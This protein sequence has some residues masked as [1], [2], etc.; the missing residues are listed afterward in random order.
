[1]KFYFKYINEGT[2]YFTKNPAKGF[3]LGIYFFGKRIFI[4]SNY[5][6]TI[7]I[8]NNIFDAYDWIVE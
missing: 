8:Y 4:T 7:R 5:N 3:I 6:H 1:M 2:A